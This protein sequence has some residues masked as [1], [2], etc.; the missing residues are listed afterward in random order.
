[1]IVVSAM[2]CTA[3]KYE[4]T[5]GHLSS[6]LNMVDFVL[7]TRELALLLRENDIYL[8]DVLEE[9]PDLLMEN[10]ES[11]VLYGMSGG[12][13]ISAVK[14]AHFIATGTEIDP[15]ALDIFYESDSIKKLTISLLGKSLH[16]AVVSGI[17]NIEI[18]MQELVENP[19]AYQYVEAMACQ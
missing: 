8:P 17:K 4:L 11:G 12:V 18:I 7:T 19:S 13:A 10:S 15:K 9:N 5:Q 3:K 1:M 16:I 14:T 2:P 6:G